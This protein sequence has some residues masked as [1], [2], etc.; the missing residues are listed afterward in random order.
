MQ[1]KSKK[2]I[3]L[4]KELIEFEDRLKNDNPDKEYTPKE[5]VQLFNVNQKSKD[6]PVLNTTDHIRIK[7]FKHFKKRAE[8]NKK[9]AEYFQLFTL[10]EME[11]LGIFESNTSEK[12]MI[13]VADIYVNYLKE[14]NGNNSSSFIKGLM[15][16]KKEIKITKNIKEKISLLNKFSEKS[17][18]IQ[19]LRELLA[20][21]C[22]DLEINSEFISFCKRKRKKENNDG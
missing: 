17:E 22:S 1:I 16:Q 13:E 10:T 18:E 8:K 11:Y 15:K 20:E 9:F 3:E 6:Q 7:H 4:F 12:K 21:L 14:N 5:V 2:K 19:K